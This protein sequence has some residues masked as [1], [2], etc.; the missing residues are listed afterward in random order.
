M[1]DKKYTPEEADAY[2]RSLT[3]DAEHELDGI[4]REID[5]VSSINTE[6]ILNIFREHRVSEPFFAPTSGYGYDDRGRDELDRIWADAFDRVT[7][8]A[9]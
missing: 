1:T 9:R 4:F 7:L 3:E 2:L 8:C 6:R 5:R